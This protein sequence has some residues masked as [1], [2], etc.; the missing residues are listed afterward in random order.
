MD[1]GFLQNLIPSASQDYVGWEDAPFLA[2]LIAVYTPSSGVQNGQNQ[3]AFI[4]QTT[5]PLTGF[6]IDAVGGRQTLPQSG[7]FTAAYA[8]ELNNVLL[9]IPGA[10]PTGY[11]NPGPY[12][13]CRLKGFLSGVPVYEFMAPWLNYLTAAVAGTGITTTWANVGSFGLTLPA[14][15][16]WLVTAQLTAELVASSG[17]SA[18]DTVSFRFFDG[19]TIHGS[20]VQGCAITCPSTTVIATMSLHAIVPVGTSNMT[21]AVQGQTNSGAGS[22]GTLLATADSIGGSYLSAVRIS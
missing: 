9:T 2:R 18:G 14:N 1:S 22:T 4:E 11:T 3:Y 13:S 19:T 8:L 17:A 6:P 10:T 20:P 15:S 12:V 21:L 5:D 7:P 16:T